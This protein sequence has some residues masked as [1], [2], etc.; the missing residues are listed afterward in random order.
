MSSTASTS[1]VVSA[2]TGPA[3]KP[4]SASSIRGSRLLQLTRRSPTLGKPTASSAKRAVAL[5]NAT[6]LTR[7]AT[8]HVPASA[9][10]ALSVS[11]FT[12]PLCGRMRS[13]PS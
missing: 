12:S 13:A 4:V 11:A 9:C 2:V 3:G 8:S 1:A 10:P 5:A 7:T 6:L